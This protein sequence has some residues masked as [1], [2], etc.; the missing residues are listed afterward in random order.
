MTAT[1]QRRLRV[2]AA[3]PSVVFVSLI[4]GPLVP[5]SQWV[6][7]PCC[8]RLSGT[9]L[10]GRDHDSHP[11]THGYRRQPAGGEKKKEINRNQAVRSRTA[12]Y[13]SC[14][15]PKRTPTTRPLPTPHTP[16]PL[17]RAV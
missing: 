4:A 17:Y 7:G 15:R 6:M 14:Q 16:L 1:A 2:V 5:S 13:Q 8:Y 11:R 12:T 9:A 3:N 10:A